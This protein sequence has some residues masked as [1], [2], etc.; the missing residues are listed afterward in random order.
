MAFKSAESIKFVSEQSI[1]V[2]MASTQQ[3][4]GGIVKMSFQRRQE[5]GNFRYNG[6]FAIRSVVRM[7]VNFIIFQRTAFY[8]VQMDF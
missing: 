1:L 6:T 5:I 8:G 3:V 2:A 4:Y 7:K